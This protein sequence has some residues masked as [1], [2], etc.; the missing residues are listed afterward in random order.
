MNAITNPV[1]GQ[2]TPTVVRPTNP[3]QTIMTDGTGTKKPTTAV[4]AKTAT[5]GWGLCVGT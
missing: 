3:I 2:G 5:T 1:N 4:A